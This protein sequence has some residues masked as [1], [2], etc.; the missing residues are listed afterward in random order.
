MAD[1]QPTRPPKV[2][3]PCPECG[4]PFQLTRSDRRFCSQRCANA[5]GNRFVSLGNTIARN[6]VAWRRAK[7]GSKEAKASLAILAEKVDQ[8]IFEEDER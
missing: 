2:T 6:A 7:A 1:T 5:E 4:G 8:F 3:V